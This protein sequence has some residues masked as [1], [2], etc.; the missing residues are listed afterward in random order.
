MGSA[1]LRLTRLALPELGRSGA[2]LAERAGAR[3]KPGC[4]HCRVE[5]KR[6]YVVAH[7]VIQMAFVAETAL[8]STSESSPGPR[9]ILYSKA[10]ISESFRS[11]LHRAVS[12]FPK[13]QPNQ[14]GV[15]VE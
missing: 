12:Q 13:E 11:Q 7:V 4:K 15:N 3:P 5:E 2:T 1:S 8:K 10:A 6:G 14:G 9:P